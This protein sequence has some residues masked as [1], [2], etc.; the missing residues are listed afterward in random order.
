MGVA[1]RFDVRDFARTAHGSLRDE[2]DR[3]EFEGFP[4]DR[5][6]IIATAYLRALELAAIAQPAGPHSSTR[7]AEFVATWAFEK[8]W[9]ADAL[10]QVLDASPRIRIAD[11]VP[12]AGRLRPLAR[13]LG[14]ALLGESLG[15]ARLAIGAI[16]AQA[17]MRGYRRLAHL[18]LHPE[19]ER[20]AT[21][22]LPI[23]ARHADF[24]TEEAAERLAGSMRARLVTALALRLARLPFGEAELPPG[25]AQEG[26]ALVFGRDLAAVAR[27]DLAL[28]RRFG[29]PVS[30]ATRLGAPARSLAVRAARR[31]GASAAEL[32]WLAR[33][34]GALR[35]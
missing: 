3:S 12:R 23:V 11:D 2:F 8:H 7:T 9:I 26:R 35:E 16:D 5:E 29:L 25:L 21:A 30:A 1:V 32:V 6:A 28:S 17:M 18:S 19:M 22:I 10:E 20:L 27:I 31:L 33:R 34:R 4:L 13:R 15:T 14:R 24:F